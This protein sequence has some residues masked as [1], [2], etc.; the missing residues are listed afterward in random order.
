MNLEIVASVLRRIEDAVRNQI[1]CGTAATITSEETSN[2][3][4]IRVMLHDD[5]GSRST[6]SEADKRGELLFTKLGKA[7]RIEKSD[8]D[9]Y[10]DRKAIKLSVGQVVEAVQTLRDQ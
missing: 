5:A 3:R 7:T 6:Y 8:V 4:I 10:L 9:A 2:D 1:S